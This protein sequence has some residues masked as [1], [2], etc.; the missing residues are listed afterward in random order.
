MLH[1][2]RNLQLERLTLAAMSLG[3]ARRS[4]EIMT[5]YAKEREAFG[6]PLSAFGQIQQMIGES[7]AEFRAAR[8]YVYDTARLMGLE[9][10]GQRLDS[11]GVK[12]FAG[13]IAKHI[14][15]RAIQ[16]LGGYGVRGRVCGR[17]PMARRQAAGN[18]RRNQ[19]GPSE[20]RY[21]AIS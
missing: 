20:K 8:T 4:L 1:M 2:M 19:R 3:I 18:R 12:L 5:K 6:K 16:A 21:T 10:H 7:F 15:D 14:A 9:S 11:D 13:P 17:A